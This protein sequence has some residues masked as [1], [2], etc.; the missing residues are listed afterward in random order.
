M[1]LLNL[2]DH[3]LNF[4]APALGVGFVCALL[5]RLSMPKSSKKRAW[6]SQGAINFAV[7]IV[8]MALGLVVFGRDGMIA[9]Y[10]ALVLACGTSQ[11]ML[12]G[13]LRR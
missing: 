12:S 11:W 5:A 1:G 13:G 8:V 3:I 4:V 7:G 9:T 6:W 2:L 10:A